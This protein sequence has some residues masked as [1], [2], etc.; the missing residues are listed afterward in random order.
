MNF[1][2]AA[3][4]RK[5]ILNAGRMLTNIHYSLPMKVFTNL[6]RKKI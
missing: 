1:K 5:V 4:E 6:N 3:N 2:N